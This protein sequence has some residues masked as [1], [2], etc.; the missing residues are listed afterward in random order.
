M[1]PGSTSSRIGLGALY[2]L[3]TAALWIGLFDLNAWAFSSLGWTRTINWVFLPAGLRLL[4]ILLWDWPGAIGLWLGA[5][6]T[7]IPLFGFQ[8]P[9]WLPAA[10]VSAAAPWI[11]VALSRRWFHLP[12]TL[13]GLTAS[14]LLKLSVVS[15]AMSV[16]MH[17]ALFWLWG[18][19][20]II[21]DVAAMLVGDLAGTLIVLYCARALLRLGDRV[22]RRP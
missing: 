3:L 5:I 20:N 18:Q 14:S 13:Q 4:G 21:H 2:A 8:S 15:A 17:S 12:P 11:A 6:A 9:R 7:G 22:M 19:R 1:A 16:A 10:T